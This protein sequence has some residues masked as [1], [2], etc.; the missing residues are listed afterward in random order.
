M[1]LEVRAR[2][3]LLGV[4]REWA[5]VLAARVTLEVVALRRVRSRGRVV[6][7]GEEVS[8]RACTSHLISAY[9]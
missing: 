1:R 8:R 5:A 6:L 2:V 9:C 3:R 4:R 7:Q